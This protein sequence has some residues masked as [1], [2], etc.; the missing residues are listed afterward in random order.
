[1]ATVALLE[2]S[3][4]TPIGVHATLAGERLAIEAFVGLPDGSEWL[5]DR[6]EGAAADPTAAG[7]LLGERLL[8][9]GA[10]DLLDR[11]EALA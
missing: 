7:V 4:T 3:C 8:T 2:A 10:R 11:A 6:V 1:R 5:G 9:A